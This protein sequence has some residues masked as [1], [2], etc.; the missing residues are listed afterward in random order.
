MKI[1]KIF[2][3]FFISV[4]S[5]FTIAVPYTAF[6]SENWAKMEKGIIRP[7]DP[8]NYYFYGEFDSDFNGE[9]LN[10]LPIEEIRSYSNYYKPESE[11]EHEPIN[12]PG[13]KIELQDGCFSMICPTEI[14]NPNSEEYDPRFSEIFSDGL[15]IDITFKSNAEFAPYL[16]CTL[17]A[18]AIDYGTVTD[19][20]ED[21]PETDETL[22]APVEDT[23]YVESEN[24]DDILN[25]SKTSSA[26]PKTGEGGVN[27]LLTVLVISGAVAY[28]INKK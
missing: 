8:Y 2:V 15:V 28:I 5:V 3:I 26:S 7:D 10:D 21:E 19:E 16:I 6:A 24:S 13:S 1:K 12:F 23:E 20:E 14:F 25:E 22:I 27:L 11:H 17:S 9:D 18:D 4:M